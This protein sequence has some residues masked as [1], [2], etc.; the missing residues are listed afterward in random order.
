MIL[1]AHYNTPLM[2][3][4]EATELGAHH[5]EHRKGPF[6]VKNICLVWEDFTEKKEG[7]GYLEGTLSIIKRYQKRRPI[8]VNFT[9]T[10][11]GNGHIL[12]Y[13]KYKCLL[14]VY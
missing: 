9:V 3:C 7:I 14:K 10:R 11:E 13:K 12:F 6:I 5:T 1:P 4:T 2:I 8:V